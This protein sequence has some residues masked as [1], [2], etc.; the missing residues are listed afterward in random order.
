MIETR[1]VETWLCHPEHWRQSWSQMF[2]N[3][4][5]S[6]RCHNSEIRDLDQT[7]CGSLGWIITKYHHFHFTTIFHRQTFFISFVINSSLWLGSHYL[8]TECGGARRGSVQC[9][10]QEWTGVC[11]AGRS[12]YYYNEPT[13]KHW[14]AGNTNTTAAHKRNKEVYTSVL[15]FD[16]NIIMSVSV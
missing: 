12:W 11:E 4:L 16:E 1:S 7:I 14:H 13:I 10:C 3:N 5:Q 9:R 6:N 8:Q 15:F 2:S